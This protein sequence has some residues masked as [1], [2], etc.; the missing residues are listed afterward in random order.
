VIRRI[1]ENAKR[2]DLENINSTRKDYNTSKIS[3]WLNGDND[4]I[5]EVNTRSEAD[6]TKENYWINYRKYLII[7]ALLTGSVVVYIYFDDIKTNSISLWE[8]FNSFRSGGTGYNGNDGNEGNNT[9]GYTTNNNSRNIPTNT[10]DSGP[11]SDDIQIINQKERF[12]S[13]SL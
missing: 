12:T 13:P 5:F 7:V 9:V 10:S 8:W 2:K 3:N 11:L 4:S 6:V 1:T